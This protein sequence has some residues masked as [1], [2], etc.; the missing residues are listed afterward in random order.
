M[1]RKL[2]FT[3]SGGG[4]VYFT[5]YQKIFN[6]RPEPVTNNFVVK[7][8]FQKNG[9]T[10]AAIKSGEKIKMIIEVNALKDA[11][12]VMLQVPIPAGCIYA[13]KNNRD[14]RVYKEF[15]KN[16][17]A[18]FTE[19]MPMG[20]HTYEIEFEPRYNGNYI[21]NPAKVELMYFPTFYG[22]NAMRKVEIVN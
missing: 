20:T 10:V 9:Q 19:S 2:S 12:F 7:T 18:L 3:K 11:E 22:R 14:W 6:T 15:Y 4:L 17:L 13:D 5:A 16:R 8:Y 21:L 1:L